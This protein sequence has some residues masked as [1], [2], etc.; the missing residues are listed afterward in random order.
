MKLILQI[1]C[2]G[3]GFSESE[4]AIPPGMTRWRW[5]R[6]SH[7]P[8]GHPPQRLV[9]GIEGFECSTP[10]IVP[11]LVES[12]GHRTLQ[13]VNLGLQSG[14]PGD[15]ALPPQP[16]LQ[17]YLVLNTGGS[18]G[19]GSSRWRRLGV[20]AARA[21]RTAPEDFATHVSIAISLCNSKSN[22]ISSSN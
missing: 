16:V 3:F 8:L 11:P 22:G 9:L 19:R 20:N 10:L 4:T 13:A 2:K 1:V 18:V 15:L 5:I 6:N 7:H 12:A 17:A 14:V 21:F